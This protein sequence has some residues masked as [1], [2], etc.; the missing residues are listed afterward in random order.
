MDK[1][2]RRWWLAASLSA[3]FAL[4]LSAPAL[5]VR[6]DGD[7]LRVSAPQFRFLSGKPLE[8]LKDGATVVFLAQLSISG[9]VNAPAIKRAIDR[10]V[11]SYDVWEEK[12]SVTQTGMERGRASYLSSAA[13]EAWCLDRLAIGIEG[14]APDKLFWVRLEMRAEDARDQAAV[15]GDSGINLS[16]LIELFSNPAHAQQMHWE[17]VAGPMRLADLIRERRSSRSG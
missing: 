13:T 5:R 11:V 8:K 3:P 12:F 4:G 17:A 9:E 7:D 2:A 14:I 1:V 6:L 15:V 16:R 10:F